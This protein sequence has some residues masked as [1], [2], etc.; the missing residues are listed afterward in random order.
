V[1]NRQIEEWAQELEDIASDITAIHLERFT[2]ERIMEIARSNPALENSE[3][4]L[5]GYLFNTYAKTQAIAVRRHADTNKRTASLGRL[6]FEAREEPELLTRDWWLGLSDRGDPNRR[7]VLAEQR[8]EH[9]GGDVG[10]HL[11]PAIPGADLAKLR[12]SSKHIRDFVN[13]N[14]AHLEA[15][16]VSHR[17]D[18]LAESEIH[19]AIDLIGHLFAKYWGLF[20]A[21]HWTGLEPVP[22]ED[23]EA[24]L[25]VPWIGGK[26]SRP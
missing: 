18:N 17:D 23:W 22:Q 16:P 19:E 5:W 8:R 11:D 9:Y 7:R 1:A 25:R 24:V 3:S 2:Y 15:R 13:R 4:L 20:K 12:H 6:I 21:S 26:R 14:V 10:G